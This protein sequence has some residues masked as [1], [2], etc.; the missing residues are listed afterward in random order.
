MR[1]VAEKIRM[2][3]SRILLLLLKAYKVTLSPFLGQRCRFYPSCSSYMMEAI[4][5]HGPLKGL[6]LGTVRF[7]KCGPWHPGGV[8]MVPP[9]GDNTKDNANH[10]HNKK[11]C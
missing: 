6:W 11:R 9:K 8:D 7:F 4:E 10:T 2:I 1:R 5:T 3:F